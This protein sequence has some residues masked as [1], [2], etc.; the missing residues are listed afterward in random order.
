[1][2][3]SKAKLKNRGDRTSSCFIPFLIGNMSDK[4]LP[5]RTF[6][7]IS[8]RHIFISLTSFRGISNSVRM[9]YKPVACSLCR[10]RYAGFI[11]IL[12]IGWFSFRYSLCIGPT[13]QMALVIENTFGPPRIFCGYSQNDHSCNAR[14]SIFTTPFNL[15]MWFTD[16]ECKAHALCAESV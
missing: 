14:K 3:F 7:Y 8:I 10:L 9:L 1:M 15:V 5:T 2:S 12:R 13:A 11:H 4:F 6:L 16:G